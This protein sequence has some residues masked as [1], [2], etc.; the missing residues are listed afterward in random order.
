[1]VP[2]PANGGREKGV[3]Q[4]LTKSGCG[5][6]KS[7]PEAHAE[8]AAREGRH[9]LGFAEHVAFLQRWSRPAACALLSASTPSGFCGDPGV[10]IGQVQ[11]GVDGGE[12][13]DG[14]E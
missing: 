2:F 14:F 8:Q 11:V 7:L 4:P 5:G 12:Q 1:M 3:K 6:A 9:E 13:T 10:S